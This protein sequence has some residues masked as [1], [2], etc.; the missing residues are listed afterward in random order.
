M[1]VGAGQ[2]PAADTAPATAPVTAAPAARHSARHSYRHLRVARARHSKA[3]HA[4]HAT[5]R[6]EQA[7]DHGDL[8]ALV[9]KYAHQEGIPPVLAHSVV[10]VESRYRPHATGHGGYIG[11]MQLS[12]HTARQMGYRGSRAALYDPETNVRYGV[13]YL[14]EAYREAH[15]KLCVTV[16]KYQGGTGVRGVTRAG[17]AYCSRVRH[18]MAAAGKPVQ[19]A[20]NG[21][22]S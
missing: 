3:H 13:R 16:S 10:M 2:I 4:S 18:F 11:L 17:A 7:A 9:V 20:D 12:Y 19:T 21:D 6:A 8:R 14:A 22:R 1:A 5:A 15:G